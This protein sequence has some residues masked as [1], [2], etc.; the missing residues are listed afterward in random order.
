MIRLFAGRPLLILNG[1]RDPNCPLG[2][3]KL[4]FAAAETAYRDAGAAEKLKILVATDTPH[5]VTDEQRQAA[6]DWLT[7]WLSA[8]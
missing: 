3:A 1:D 7:T 5:K 8:K 6:L 4:A 2:G